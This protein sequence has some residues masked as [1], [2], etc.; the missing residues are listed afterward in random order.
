[1][2]LLYLPYTIILISERYCQWKSHFSNHR[3]H[4]MRKVSSETS[5][6]HKF[7]SGASPLAPGFCAGV[8]REGAGPAYRMV[9]EA[10]FYLSI[11][12]AEITAR[13]LSGPW[14]HLQQPIPMSGCKRIT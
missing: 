7:Q 6:G 8:C 10:G 12:V 2:P 13:L 3:G 1:M 14:V 4:R 5:L 9:T 11:S